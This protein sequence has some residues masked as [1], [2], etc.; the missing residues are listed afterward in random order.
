MKSLKRRLTMMNKSTQVM[1]TVLLVSV[2]AL[3]VPQ[4]YVMNTP[5]G[6]DWQKFYDGMYQAE[7][8][9]EQDRS[10]VV[11]EKAYDGACYR[12][13]KKGVVPDAVIQKHGRDVKSVA[14]FSFD[15]GWDQSKHGW[16]TL[17]FCYKAH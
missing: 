4:V 3:A 2:T 15:K 8:Q 5:G 17:S 9:Q 1:G 12:F 11:L 16:W 7:L 6:H 14:I 10:V 13:S